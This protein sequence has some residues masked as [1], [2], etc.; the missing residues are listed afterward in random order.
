MLAPARQTVDEFL[1]QPETHTPTE[2]FDGAVIVSPAPALRH[3]RLVFH[4]A[5]L[6][7]RVADGRG[8]VLIAPVDVVLDDVTVAQPDLLWI[9]PDSDR[10]I[11]RDGRLYGAPD[12]C[13]EI[14]SPSTARLDRTTK[15][16]A[17]E[18]AGVREYWLVEPSA[19]TVEV[20]TLGEKEYTLVGVYRAP[21]TAASPALGQAVAVAEVFPT[22]SPK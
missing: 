18:R 21:Q 2:L 3:Q 8:E 16:T 9:A 4:L 7:E 11:E 5:K 22:E 1:A 19:E 12:L 15:F 17:Y 6:I 14:L 10:C 20:W 13:V